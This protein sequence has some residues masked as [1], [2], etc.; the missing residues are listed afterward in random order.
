MQMNKISV[1]Q[2][3]L[4]ALATLRAQQPTSIQIAT[5]RESV[6]RLVNE[7]GM[8]ITPATGAEITEYYEGHKSSF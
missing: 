6:L 8:D 2:H 4:Y 7:L 1:R 3:A 5:L